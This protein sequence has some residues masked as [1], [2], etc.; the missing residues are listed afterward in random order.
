MVY[1]LMARAKTISFRSEKTAQKLEA[2][3]PKMTS[4]SRVAIQS[5]KGVEAPELTP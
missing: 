3:Y 2:V 1:S 5:Q 4:E